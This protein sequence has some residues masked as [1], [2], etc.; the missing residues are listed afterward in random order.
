MLP[1]F[2]DRVYIAAGQSLSIGREDLEKVLG[3]HTVALRIGPRC[4]ADENT[5]W[6]AELTINILSRLY[7]TIAL[8][9]DDAACDSLAGIAQ[10]VNP[11][12]ELKERTRGKVVVEIGMASSRNQRSIRPSAH[13]WVAKLSFGIGDNTVGLPNPYSAAVAASFASAEVF[14]RMFRKHL[15]RPYQRTSS[16]F[17][18]S[19][20]DHGPEAGS[21]LPLAPHDLGRVVLAGVGAVANPAL[22]AWARHPGIT[23][24]MWSV[25][26]DRIDL[27]NLERY[28]LAMDEDGDRRPTK[29]ALAERELAQSSIHVYP[30]EM[31]LEDFACQMGTEFSFPTICI[32]VD[33]I[34]PR[35]VAQSLLPKLVVNGGTGEGNAGASW[36]HFDG[37]NPCLCCV[38]HPGDSP[39]SKTQQV[40]NALGLDHEIVKHLWVGNNVIPPQYFEQVAQHLGLSD[41]QKDQWRGRPVCEFYT[42]FICGAVR[43]ELKAA[44]KAASVPLAHQSLLAGALMAAELVKR[45]N[46][47]L[48]ALSQPSSVFQCH[49]V[50]AP[51]GAHW[52]SQGIRSPVPGCICQD[53]DY[54]TV[55]GEKWG[56]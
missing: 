34:E 48:S 13:G 9:G 5:R 16:D 44:K 38:Y 29:V 3:E 50:R 30:E 31:R 15:P 21:T 7:P 6:I 22:W 45:T 53:P 43:M 33:D 32:S 36:H 28:L 26:P 23:G 46:P 54:R 27:G 20:L 56:A 39:K 25:D 19:L 42:G 14:R 51:F 52:I 37:R 18:F 1:R 35:R 24:E 8:S 12:I 17:S 55:F 47:Q 10:A 4:R 41:E 49:D 2:F 11:A 40:A